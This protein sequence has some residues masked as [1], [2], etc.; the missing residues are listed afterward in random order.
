MKRLSS[1]LCGLGLCF[2]AENALAQSTIRHPGEH[3]LY[4]VELE[5]HLLFGWIQPPGKPEGRGLGFG[6]RATIPIVQNGFI[7]TINNSVGI[8]F[9]IDWIHYDDD[10]YIAYDSCRRWVPTPGDT[11]TCVEL[12]GRRG[13]SSNYLYFPVAMQWNFW[14]HEK[15]SVFGEPG[16]ALYYD[17]PRYDSAHLGMAPAFHIGG[18]WHFARRGMLTMRIGYPSISLGVSVLF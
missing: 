11:R 7:S 4:S 18:R 13:G 12:W 10:D 3:P 8:S 15:F 2:A 1:F 5:P 16:L 14:L 6:V 17:K 9:G